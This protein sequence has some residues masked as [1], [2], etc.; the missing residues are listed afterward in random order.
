MTSYRLFPSP[1][2]YFA[3]GLPSIV[4]EFYGN[5][6]CGYLLPKFPCDTPGMLEYGRCGYTNRISADE[7]YITFLVTKL[8]T[9]GFN[10]SDTYLS[11]YLSA[12]VIN[13]ANN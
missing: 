13:L 12:G 3:T 9:I 8:R 10:P 7:E 6:R 1:N 2:Y 4:S 5:L 11:H